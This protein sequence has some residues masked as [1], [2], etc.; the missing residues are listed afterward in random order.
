MRAMVLEQFGGRFTLVERPTPAPCH[1]EVLVRVR[2]CGLGLSLEHARKGL[3]GGSTPRVLGHELAGTVAA[4]GAGVEGWAAGDRVTTSFY[5]LCGR[6]HRCAE[7][8]ET[9]C[10]NNKGYFGL[11]KDGAFADFVAIPAHNLVR[12]PDA[13]E[14]DSAGVVADALA[15]PYHVALKRARIAAGQ[16]VAVI[17]AG[18]GVG[19]HMLQMVRAFGGVPIAVERDPAKLAELARRGWA[20]RIVDAAREDWVAEL[21]RAADDRLDVCVDMVA[22]AGTLAAGVD[23]LGVGGTLVIVGFDVGADVLASS[24][25]MLQQELTVTGSRYATRAEIAAT[26]DLV[27]L[28]AVEPVIGASFPLEQLNEAFDA[29]RE[30]ATF[31]RVLIRC[32]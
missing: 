21:R 11:V 19:V 25:R 16:R 30:A 10:V 31:G 12:V 22:S 23:A 13:V 5:M 4:V 28:G 2:A 24:S 29:V 14:L 1:D 7:G 27:A 15:T 20:E 6:C 32:E 26:L 9:L 17:G 3:L 8:R 18:G